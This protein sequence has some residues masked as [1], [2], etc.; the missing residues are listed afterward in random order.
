MLQSSVGTMVTLRGKSHGGTVAASGFGLD[1]IG[2]A[3][4][5]SEADK[6]LR[7]QKLG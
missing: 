5:P 6:D 7:E 2:T 4:V 3:C 1:I